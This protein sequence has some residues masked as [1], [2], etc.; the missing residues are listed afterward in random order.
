MLIYGLSSV[1]SLL[2]VSAY[3][4]HFRGFVCIGHHFLMS[5]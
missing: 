3:T 2:Y 4:I 5:I 1:D